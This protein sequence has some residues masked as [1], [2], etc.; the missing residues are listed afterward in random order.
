MNELHPSLGESPGRR[1]WPPL[2]IVI[3]ALVWLALAVSAAGLY[4]ATLPDGEATPATP[5]RF[6]FP[7]HAAPKP[8]PE[9]GFEDAQGAKHTL[10][11]FRGRT[12]LLNIWAT[13]C[14]PCRKEMPALDRLQ[15][16]LGGPAF[17]VLVLSIDT[18]GAAA[19]RRFYKEVGI[20]ALAVYVDPTTRASDKLGA[21]GIPT[22]LLV[23]P[24]G[25][26]VARRTGQAE[27][28]SPDAVAIIQ[29]YMQRMNGASK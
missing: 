8:L 11:D 21:I 3:G 17:Q 23:D 2:R 24:Q 26:E 27:W 14:V 28:D 25:R 20:R 4:Y 13:W 10:A 6:S 15:Q 5:A 9:I 16:K 22:T 12:V 7:L 18:E 19:V 29:Q 1:K